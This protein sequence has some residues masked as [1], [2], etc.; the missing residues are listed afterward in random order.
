MIPNCSIFG[1]LGGLVMFGPSFCLSAMSMSEHLYNVQHNITILRIFVC[2]INNSL[3]NV[4]DSIPMVCNG[5]TTYL[6]LD[7][8]AF[9]LIIKGSSMAS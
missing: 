1:R 5:L 6:I 3:A 7:L 4:V 8:S 9:N 2:T